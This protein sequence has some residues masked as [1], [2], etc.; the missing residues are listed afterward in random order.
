[1]WY[2]QLRGGVSYLRYLYSYK[3]SVNLGYKET[4]SLAVRESLAKVLST[5]AREY[6]CHRVDLK[7][8]VATA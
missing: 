2:E 3:C 5:L 8:A 6:Q 1:M 4:L 7:F